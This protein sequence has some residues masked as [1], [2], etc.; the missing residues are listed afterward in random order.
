MPVRS[1]MRSCFSRM[2]QCFCCLVSQCMAWLCV[3][4]VL[5]FTVAKVRQVQ[6]CTFQVCVQDHLSNLMTMHVAFK[7]L[8]L[9]LSMEPV[10]F[11]EQ[12][13]LNQI[14]SGGGL[15][16]SCYYDMCATHP[17]WFGFASGWQFLR[18]SWVVAVDSPCHCSKS[19]S[20]TFIEL[21]S[22]IANLAGLS[23][24]HRDVLL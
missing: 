20:V 13:L 24:T 16:A 5:D 17:P 10:W 1:A 19:C 3:F 21:G 22:H 4:V 6:I 23:G 18:P 8:N 9:N 7:A 15:N 11:F 2:I 14:C 12:S